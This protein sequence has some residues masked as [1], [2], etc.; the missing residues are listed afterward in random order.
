MSYF[1]PFK[2]LAMYSMKEGISSKRKR[3]QQYELDNILVTD[4]T[5]L[6]G[7]KPELRNVTNMTDIFV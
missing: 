3:R 2:Y 5:I 4:E 6:P 7:K 1:L